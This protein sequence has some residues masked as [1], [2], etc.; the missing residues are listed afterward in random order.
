MDS[1]AVV[2]ELMMRAEE[3]NAPM[4][5]LKLLG[6]DESV[7]DLS[8]REFYRRVETRLERGLKQERGIARWASP[9]AEPELYNAA[10]R[11]GA[12]ALSLAVLSWIVAAIRVGD[13]VRENISGFGKL[14]Y[15]G[16]RRFGLRE[17]ICRR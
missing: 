12:G 9:I 7:S 2:Q 8:F 14:S 5:D 10:L 4:R 13:A 1:P 11:A 6:A 3:H 17:V 16:R 15:Q